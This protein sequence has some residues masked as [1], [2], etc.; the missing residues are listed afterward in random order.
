MIQ[1]TGLVGLGGKVIIASTGRKLVNSNDLLLGPVHDRDQRKRVGVEVRVIVLLA[2]IG[3]ENEALKEAPILICDIQ[4]AI[5]PRLDNDLES[6]RKLKLL[7]LV[8]KERGLLTH[9]NEGAEL[10]T[11]CAESAMTWVGKRDSSTYTVRLAWNS[12]LMS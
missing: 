2:C 10:G 11:V 6:W 12:E 7:D 5:G 9:F 4:S 8:L 1:H 3:R